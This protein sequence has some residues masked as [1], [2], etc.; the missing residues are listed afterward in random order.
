[1]A[2][3]VK[4]ACLLVFNI[5]IEMVNTIRKHLNDLIV[6]KPEGLSDFNE[7]ITY[8]TDRPNHDVRYAIDANKINK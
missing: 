5:I 4:P 2:D 8:V 1:M 3:N 6:D 7:L